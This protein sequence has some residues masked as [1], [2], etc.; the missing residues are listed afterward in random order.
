M[1][2]EFHISQVH[3][4]FQLYGGALGLSSA[5]LY[6]GASFHSQQIAL[7]RGA[8]I[9]VGTPGRIK[10]GYSLCI[11]SVLFTVLVILVAFGWWNEIQ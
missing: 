4:D 5:C 10:V 7:K 2:S 3:A 11:F 8:D 9:V 6:G 1:F